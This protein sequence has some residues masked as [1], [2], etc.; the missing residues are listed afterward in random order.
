MNK[1]TATNRPVNNR[2]FNNAQVNDAPRTGTSNNTR[3]GINRP[4]TDRHIP[5]SPV[6]TKEPSLGR[7][8]AIM[9][10]G[11]LLS[12]ITGIARNALLLACLGTTL[13]GDS[14]NN[15]N[16]T[17]NMVYELVAG[18]VLSAL[19]VPLFNA[20]IQKNTRR[21]TDGINAIV[22][23]AF[24][25]LIVTAALV[26]V[27]APTI[28]G[29]YFD[30]PSQVLQRQLGS[31]LLRMFAPQIAVYGLITLATAA[32]STKRKFGVVMLAPVFNNLV[33][34]VVLSWAYRI[35]NR[36]FARDQGTQ[37]NEAIKQLQ[38]VARN[39]QAKWILGF[40][41]TAGVLAM[42]LVLIPALRKADVR[43]RWH[44]EPTH[45][46]VTE[47]LRLS[48]WTMG[49]VAANQAA[50]LFVQNRA[51][52][53][54]GVSGGG[55]TMYSFA[56]SVLFLLPHSLFVV[57]IMTALQ[58]E[59]SMAFLQRSRIRFRTLLTTNI[60]NTLAVIVPS[61]VG[62]FVLASPLTKLLKFGKVSAESAER[63]GQVVQA[64]AIGLPAFSVYLLL[65]NALKAMR[66][67]KATF[68][69]NATECAINI[70]LA[71]AFVQ[72]G[73][74]VVGLGLAFSLAYIIS[75]FL[76]LQTVS[77][78]TNGL[79]GR[80]LTQSALRIAISGAAMGV[81]VWLGSLGTKKLVGQT[82]DSQL[83]AITQIGVG[84]IVGVTVYVVV[85]RLVGVREL[86]VFLSSIGRRLRRSRTTENTNK[87]ATKTTTK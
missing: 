75:V 65:M 39:S 54:E 4:L 14:Y 82:L 32:L 74:G 10:A 46:A 63:L 42:G 73:W 48:G 44:W 35:L 78:R 66:D 49:Y 84:V 56:Y 2:P 26:A 36:L 52:K 59:L 67:T 71:Y 40:G 37:S 58:P 13:L 29:L 19:L 79:N 77:K 69:V 51:G 6:G 45:P 17:P 64:M 27:G 81:M 68:T 38:A 24:V 50:V 61:G 3:P 20:L 76:A 57:S 62:L 5:A 34:I 23:L 41:T 87:P 12:R 80:Q 11:T 18:G 30:E 33:M 53:A 16:T 28:M 9:T 86:D 8:T 43:W 70:V 7:S 47:L 60:A 15:A 55:S 21:A 22:S 83:A 25:G 1:R 72:A 85:A 31:E